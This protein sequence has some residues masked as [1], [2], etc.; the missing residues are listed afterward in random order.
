MLKMDTLAT[1]IIPAS[2]PAPTTQYRASIR[3][4]TRKDRL[5]E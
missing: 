4:Q 3:V 5:W 2:N 1:K